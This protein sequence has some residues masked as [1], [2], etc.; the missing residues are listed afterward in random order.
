MY[1]NKVNCSLTIRQK[2]W[3]PSCSWLNALIKTW[4][5]LTNRTPCPKECSTTNLCFSN[6]RENVVVFGNLSENTG[7]QSVQHSN[8]EYN[9]QHHVAWPNSAFIQFHTILVT[10]RHWWLELLFYSAIVIAGPPFIYFNS[11]R[12]QFFKSKTA[13]DSDD[14]IGKTLQ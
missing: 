5:Y 9:H 8:H 13:K 2:A 4:D 10:P 6:E 11:H 3:I 12:V 1:Q 7:I 14:N